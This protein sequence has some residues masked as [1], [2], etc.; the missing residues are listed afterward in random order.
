MYLSTII[1]SSFAL[2]ASTAHAATV[3]KVNVGA[4][5]LK[6]EPNNF[7]AEVGSFVEFTFFPKVRYFFSF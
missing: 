1:S 6:F 3:Y 4:N 5:G 7:T 2:L